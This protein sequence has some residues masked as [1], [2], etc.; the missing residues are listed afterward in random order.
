MGKYRGLSVGVIRVAGMRNLRLGASLIGLSVFVLLLLRFLPEPWA[1]DEYFGNS[2]F[3]Y[4]VLGLVFYLAVYFLGL[5]SLEYFR[6][7]RFHYLTLVAVLVA[8]TFV[9]LEF[10]GTENPHIDTWVAVGGV[11]FLLAIGFGEEMFSRAF[12]FGVLSKF[13]NLRAIFFSSTLFGLMHL[14]L[15]LGADWDPWEAY[16]H[17][18]NT[19]AFGVFAC[20]LMIVTRSIWMAVLFHGLSDWSV[21]FDIPRESSAG[22][23]DWDV[24]AWEGFTAPFGN[25]TIFIGCAAFLLWLDRGSVPAW[26]YRLARKWKLIRLYHELTA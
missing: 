12:T 13:G 11:L 24:S 16:W 19:A 6:L 8:S 18:I 9:A 25:V 26:M 21:V 22:R 14:N 3:S 7:P 5:P 23:Q 20:A 17:V 4:F 2:I 15:Y 1:D 10:E